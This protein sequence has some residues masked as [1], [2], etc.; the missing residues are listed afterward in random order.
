MLIILLYYKV[1]NL[2]NLNIVFIT[3]SVDR[4]YP[5]S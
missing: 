2:F 5:S 1:N 4:E 3:L